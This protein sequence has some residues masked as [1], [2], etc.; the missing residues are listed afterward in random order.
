[1][2]MDRKLYPPNWDA[3]ASGIKVEVNW[4]CEGCCRRYNPTGWRT[5]GDQAQRR[6]VL[7]EMRCDRPAPLRWP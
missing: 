5:Q 4:C 7:G 2:P 6:C 3:I 1:M